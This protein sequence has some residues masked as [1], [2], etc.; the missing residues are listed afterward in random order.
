MKKKNAVTNIKQGKMFTKILDIQ[1]IQYPGLGLRYLTY[2]KVKAYF[3]YH[4][5]MHRHYLIVLRKLSF[6]RDEKKICSTK[7][8]TGQD[9]H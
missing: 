8:K 6:L 2:Q 3:T 7:H 5:D 1:Y 9:V 4:R